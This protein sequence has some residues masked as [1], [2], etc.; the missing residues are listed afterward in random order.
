MTRPRHRGPGE[1][2]EGT[3]SVEFV[4]FAIALL[5]PLAYLLVTVF[6]VQ[7]A[8]YGVSSASR[9]AGR[10]FV[11]APAGTD[12]QA[13]A[14]TAAWVALQDHGIDLAPGQLVL[15]CSA[16]PCLTPDAT[17]EVSIGLEVALPLLPNLFDEAPASVAVHG[18]HTAIVDRFRPGG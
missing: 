17:V 14:Y 10:A 9:E 5:I 15:S 4:L 16:T 6:S 12:P 11:Q 3:A 1:A 13:L 2:D 8:A 7:S 18:R